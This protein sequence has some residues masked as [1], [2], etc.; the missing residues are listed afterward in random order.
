MTEDKKPELTLRGQPRRILAKL[1][2]AFKAHVR[3]HT[4]NQKGNAWEAAAS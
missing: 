3:P 4:E 2:P 1:R